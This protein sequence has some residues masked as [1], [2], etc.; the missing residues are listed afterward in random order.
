MKTIEESINELNLAFKELILLLAKYLKI[1][2]FVEWLS[3][4]INKL[5]K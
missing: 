3:N 2:L 4:N 1:D 5:V